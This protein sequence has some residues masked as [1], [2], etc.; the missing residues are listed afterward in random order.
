MDLEKTMKSPPELA[1]FALSVSD[2]PF[3]TK[4]PRK[5]FAWSYFAE[6]LVQFSQPLKNVF[7]HPVPWDE[8]IRTEF[9][10]EAGYRKIEKSAHAFYEFFHN[11]KI[12]MAVVLIPD[13]ERWDIQRFRPLFGTIERVYKELGIPV[14]NLESRIPAI[15]RKELQL[16]DFDPRPNAKAHTIIAQEIIRFLEQENLLNRDES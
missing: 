15:A 3:H 1:L 7:V 11:R 5:L 6:L 16:S 12:P 8:K 14:L 9:S 4:E 2:I 10:S 13:F